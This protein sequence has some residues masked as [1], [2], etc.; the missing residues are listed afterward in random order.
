[1]YNPIKYVKKRNQPCKFNAALDIHFYNS[2]IVIT[3]SLD[4]N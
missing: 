2:F 1:M 3:H 4:S